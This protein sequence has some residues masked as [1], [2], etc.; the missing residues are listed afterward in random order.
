MSSITV[1]NLTKSFHI[2][3]DEGW[4]NKTAIDNLS[5]CI[6]EGEKVGLIGLNGSGKTT[7]LRLIGGIYRPS[8]GRIETQ[9]KIISFLDMAWPNPRL[10]V[11]DN[12]FLGGS[13]YGLTTKEI[14]KYLSSIAEFAEVEAYL[15][16][17][18][19]HLSAGMQERLAIATA[20]Y[21]AFGHQAGIS[22]IDE[23][24]VNCDASFVNKTINKFEEYSGAAVT[25]LMAGHNF[26]V[27]LKTC[28]QIIWLDHGKIVKMGESQSIV[29]EF[30]AINRGD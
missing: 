25:I 3:T 13:L 12:I 30:L 19:Y 22:L 14:S 20:L 17:P 29:Q 21:L 24:F 8:A 7:L 9:G 26:E 4:L 5:F 27:M 18:L 28:S 15:Q 1:K 16:S 10:S 6:S 11:A 23:M 2:R